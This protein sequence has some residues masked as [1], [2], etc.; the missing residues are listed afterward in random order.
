MNRNLFGDPR[1]AFP[2]MSWVASFTRVSRTCSGVKF[3]CWANTS[4]AAPVTWGVDIEVP[5]STRTESSALAKSDLIST[6]GA[7]MSTQVPKLEKDA[8]RSDRSVAPTVMAA[9][10]RAGDSL[11]ASWLSLPAAA[12]YVTPDAMDALTALS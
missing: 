4:A 5:L 1:P 7:K 2:T 8:R 11:H 3:G 10:S 6:P 12:T 9:G